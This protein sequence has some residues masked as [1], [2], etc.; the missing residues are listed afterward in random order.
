MPKEASLEEQQL[1]QFTQHLGTAILEWQSVEEQ[2][3]LV[4]HYLLRC[5][6]INISS[7]I[8]H[9]IANLNIKL[10]MIDGAAKEVLGPIPLY[11][12]WAKL[13]KRI[14]AAASRRNDLVHFTL[15]RHQ[16]ARNKK[17]LFFLRS[18]VF[19]VT[20]RSIREWSTNDIKQ[21][22]QL[23]IKLTNDIADF[24]DVALARRKAMT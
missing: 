15:V 4:F 18:S 14:R 7:M 3:F 1:Q 8:Y 20:D 13:Y 16:P 24:A 23:F 2:L 17:A 5:D 11:N 9:S 12:K 21:F 6:V 10:G 19:D 22:A